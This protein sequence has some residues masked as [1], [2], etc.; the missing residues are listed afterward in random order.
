M[1]LLLALL[2][3]CQ[4]TKKINKMNTEIPK[5]SEFPLGEENIAFE[6]YFIGK[7]YLA[8][9]TKNEELNVPIYN[10]TFE[11]RAR[12]NWHSHTGGQI[13]IVVVGEGLYQE[14]GKPAQKLKVGDVVEIAPNVVH[15]HGATD[16]SWFSHLAITCNPKTNENK[17]FDSVNEEDYKEANS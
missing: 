6:K 2:I 17:W 3:S 8:Q 12:N 13:L 15:W 4:T 7:S 9:I 14:K 10:V 11:P 1:F 16:K 5:I